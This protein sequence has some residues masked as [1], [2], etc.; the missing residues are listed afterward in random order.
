M[1]KQALSKLRVDIDL[2]DQKILSLLS[3]RG[4]KVTQVGKIKKA[5][6]AQ[7]YVPEREVQVLNQ[8]KKLNKGPYSNEAV[9][10]IFK[11]IISAS[12]ALE[13]PVK[14]A[15]LG[16]EAT[17][18]HQAAIKRFGLSA[19]FSPQASI[20]EVFSKVQLKEADYG[21]VPIENSSEGVVS[22]TLDL[23][24][25]HSLKICGEVKLPITHQLLSK[26]KQLG[27]IKHLYSHPQ[28]L[29]Q[30]RSWI[31][32]HL[33]GVE[34][35]EVS[36][37]SKAAQ[38]VSSTKQAA[39]IASSYAATHYGLAVLSKN[40]EDLVNNFTRFVVIGHTS[41]QKSESD[42]TSLLFSTKDEAGSLFKILSYLAKEKINLSKIESRPLKGRAWEY[43]FFIDLEGH[44]EEKN[45]KRALTKMLQ[46]CVFLKSLGSYPRVI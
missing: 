36:S 30:C 17:F 23:F 28:A 5:Q 40:I 22:H 3:T 32:Q 26:E 27:Q 44:E 38:I 20:A 9:E 7:F 4:K 14:I 1:S 12:L 16:P 2:I 24:V 43:I 31:N 39:A 11:E 21:I 46:N 25:E 6:N 42:K 33:K 45:V 37:T 35:H 13:A 41:C 10:I 18:T 29:A 8:L 19:Q 34:I 15:F